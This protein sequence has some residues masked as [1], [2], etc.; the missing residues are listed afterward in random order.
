MIAGEIY[1]RRK[2]NI[3]PSWV[4]SLLRRSDFKSLQ[5]LR[6]FK[7]KK[8]VRQEGLGSIQEQ[9]YTG[10]QLAYGVTSPANAQRPRLEIVNST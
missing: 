4:K 5:L 7:H 10:K 8:Q 1:R 6:G 2:K 9:Y 3:Y